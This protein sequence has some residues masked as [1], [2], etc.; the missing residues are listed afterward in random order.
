MSR[1]SER[2][3]RPGGGRVRQR[4]ADADDAEQADDHVKAFVRF[5]RKLAFVRLVKCVDSVEA[6]IHRLSAMLGRF[7]CQEP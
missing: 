4:V 7:D 2:C 1:S 5:Y 6:G 3:G